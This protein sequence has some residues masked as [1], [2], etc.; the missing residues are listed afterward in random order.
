MSSPLPAVNLSQP[1]VGSISLSSPYRYFRKNCS[2]RVL[3]WLQVS[4][5]QGVLT[6][7]IL[8]ST[9]RHVPVAHCKNWGY[10]PELLN[11]QQLGEAVSL[12]CSGNCTSCI[13]PLWA[14]LCHMPCTLTLKTHGL[15]ILSIPGLSFSV[16]NVVFVFLGDSFKH[17]SWASSRTSI[18]DESELPHTY[19]RSSLLRAESLILSMSWSL[20]IILSLVTASKEHL[21]TEL[22]VP[23]A[24]PL[25]LSMT[26]ET[27]Q[28]FGCTAVVSKGIALRHC[29]ILYIT[30]LKRINSPLNVLARDE[31]TTGPL[32]WKFVAREITHRITNTILGFNSFYRSIWIYGFVGK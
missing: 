26:I 5:K 31:Y 25:L 16:L 28:Q 1:E 30:L 18:M 21:N 9:T 24:L 32:F 27:M 11:S 3:T 7:P 29:E 14:I 20:I 4:K 22:R 2:V 8:I 10:S 12:I 23:N 6:S 19:L 15:S 17:H 13:L